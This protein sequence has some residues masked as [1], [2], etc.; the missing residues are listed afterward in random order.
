M[1][2]T[3]GRASLNGA[4][5]YIPLKVYAANVMPIIFAQAIMFIPYSVAPLFGEMSVRSSRLISITG[6]LPIT[7]CLPC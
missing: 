3:G 7:W 2:A 1:S 6:V 4:R 5:Q